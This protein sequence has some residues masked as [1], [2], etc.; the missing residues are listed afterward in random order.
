VGCNV[1]TLDLYVEVEI[2]AVF[3]EPCVINETNFELKTSGPKPKQ[4]NLE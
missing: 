2:P 3:E 1:A 4:K